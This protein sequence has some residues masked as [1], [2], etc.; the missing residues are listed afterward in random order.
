MCSDYCK[1]TW[2][3]TLD[4]AGVSA[5]SELRQPG[6]MYYHPDIHEI[7]IA[8]T[9]VLESSEQPLAMQGLPLPLKPPKDPP[10]LVMKVKKARWAKIKA[11][12][13]RLGSSQ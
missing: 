6:K 5:S 12:V 2:E 13:K 1:K 7:P 11:K 9:T 10:R 4:L 8:P 3:K